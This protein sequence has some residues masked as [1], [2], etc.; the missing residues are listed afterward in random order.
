MILLKP[1]LGDLAPA[2]ELIGEF[3]SSLK[4]K[5]IPGFNQSYARKQAAYLKATESYAGRGRFMRLIFKS[6]KPPGKPPPGLYNEMTGRLWQDWITKIS[7]P[8]DTVPGLT[9]SERK[10]LTTLDATLDEQHFVLTG[11]QSRFDE[12]RVTIAVGPSG[13]CIVRPRHDRPVLDSSF[14][15]EI[16]YIPLPISWPLDKDEPH[17]E[18]AARLA[19]FKTI[20]E[21][22]SYHLSTTEDKPISA[23]KIAEQIINQEKDELLKLAA[24][25]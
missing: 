5:W 1:S 17:D 2:Y 13:V 11:L 4:N 12:S 25:L 22:A 9:N 20:N 19:I 24:T 14:L 16:E 23:L 7:Y 21:L 15:P 18:H 8:I 6:P 10:L 3:S